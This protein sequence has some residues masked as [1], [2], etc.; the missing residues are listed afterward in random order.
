MFDDPNNGMSGWAFWT[1][2]KVPNARN[3]YPSLTTYPVSDGWK[4]LITA[5]SER[6][7]ANA[8]PADNALKGTTDFINSLQQSKPILD[9]ELARILTPNQ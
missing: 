3:K 1:W 5:A 6:S 2:K 9:P 4:Q 7:A 8:L